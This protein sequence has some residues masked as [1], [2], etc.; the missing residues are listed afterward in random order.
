MAGKH[1][2]FLALCV[3][4]LLVSPLTALAAGTPV[5][6]AVGSSGALSA[7]TVG[8][9]DEIAEP[10]T[11]KPQLHERT[12]LWWPY[13]EGPIY[14]APSGSL[15]GMDVIRLAVG[16]IRAGESLDLPAD[17]V[18]DTG[19]IARGMAQ[20]FLVQF[21]ADDPGAA[22]QAIESMGAVVVETIPVNAAIVRLDGSNYDRVASSPAV[23]FIE[24]Y[25]PAFRIHPAVGQM[26]QL[27]PEAAA[28]P[29][30]ELSVNLFPGEA[31]APVAQ[32]IEQLGGVVRA[33][34]DG[35]HPELWIS[36]NA[37]LIPQLARLEPV[38]MI[39]ERG[40]VLPMAARGSLFLQS[41]S[42]LA[43]DYPYWEAGVDGDGQIIEVDDSGLSVDAGDFSDTAAD[44]GWTGTGGNAGPNVGPGHR[45]V[46]AYRTASSLS[47]GG[48]GDLGACDSAASG[49]F[50]HGQVVGGVAAGNATRDQVPA[51]SQP[52]PGAG[53]GPGFYDD[54]NA[55]G[56]FDEIN[57]SAFD[58]IAKGAK[59]VFVDAASGCPDAADP[60][61]QPGNLNTIITQTSQQY[62]AHIHNFSFGSTAP[63]T[64]PSYSAGADDID[65]AIN[66]APINFVAISAGND[67]DPDA[68]KYDI[69][70]QGNEASCKNC[71]AVGA[72]NGVGG[73][74]WSFTSGGT[75]PGR[76][77]LTLLF[78]EGADNSCRSEDA[79]E[80]PAENQTGPAT[81]RDAG[82]Q[83]GTSF[84]SPNLAGAAAVIRDYFAKGFYP[85][86]TDRNSNNPAEQVDK[87]SGA[88]IKAIMIA[89]AQPL[90]TGRTVMPEDRFNFYW[91]Y[92]RVQLNFSL[93]LSDFPGKTVSGLIV[94][95]SADGT[96]IDNDGS[97]DSTIASLSL[98]TGLL[99]ATPTTYTD[100][101]EVLDDTEDLVVAL[102]WNDVV[103]QQGTIAND[104]DLRLRYCG[105]DGTCGNGD[106]TVWAGNVF[107][108]DYDRDGTID[109]DLN[110]NGQPDEYFYSLE[111]R[112]P[113]DTWVD[114]VNNTEAVFVPTE[115]NAQDKDGDGTFDMALV[116]TGT[117]R[118]EIERVSGS[119]GVLYALA[120]TGGVAAG[121]SARF[122]TNPLVC[123]ADVGVLVNE[124]DDPADTD[125]NAGSC[126][127]SVISARTTVEV[128]DTADAVVDT[129]TG[130]AFANT[131]GLR[132]ESNR[133]PLSADLAPAA[134][135]GVLSVDNGYKLR[136][137]YQDTDTDRK[138]IATVDCQPNIEVQL[139]RQI[140]KD[141]P[142][143]LVGGCDDDEY[144]D[145]GEA[146]SIELEYFNLDPF[147]LIDAQI[148]LRAV[149]PYPD[150]TDPQTIADDPCRLNRP[151][152][153]YI[154]I[155][156]PVNDVAVL[157][158][159]TRQRTN[160]TFQVAGTP[161][162]RE[163]V[164]LV[165]GLTGAKTGQP[166]QDCVA[167]SFLL[168][169]DDEQNRYITDCPTGCTADYDL[170][171]DE[172]WDD[173][174]PRNPFDPI[175]F[176]NRGED[177][178]AIVYGDLTDTSF[179]GPECPNCGNDAL[180]FTG[181]WNFD[182]D[183][184]GF[185][186]GVSPLSALS[187][188]TTQ[189]TNWGED[190]NWD[191]TLQPAE[192]I[193]PDGA[194]G[195]LDQNWGLGGGC[196]FVSS[197]GTNRGIWHT[198]TIGTWQTNHTTISCRPDDTICEEYDVQFGTTG[199][200]YWFQTLRTP[201]IHPVRLGT[202]ADGFEWTAQIR[203]WSW[204]WQ[205]DTADT[206]QSWTWEFDLD[207]NTANPLQLGDDFIGGL[208]FGNQLGVISGGQT[209]IF[210]GAFAFNPTIDDST[211]IN[212]GDERLGSKGNDRDS[213]RGCYF[214]DLDLEP[215][216]G[217][218]LT[219]AERQVNPVRPI[220]DDCD[221]NFDLV[222]GC[223]G[224]C[225]V[226]D[227]GNGAIDDPFEICPCR[228]CEAGSPRAGQA[229]LTAAQCNPEPG[230]SFR[231]VDN[232]N[233][234]GV[235]SGFG[236][237]I[238]GNGQTDEN[239]LAD[240]GTAAGLRQI[241]NADI[242]MLNGVAS[243]GRGAGD[244]RFNTLDDFY[245]PTG[246]S[247]AGELGFLVAEPEGNDAAL[248]SYGIGVDDMVVEWIE[249]HPIDDTAAVCTAGNPDY[250][251]QCARI[252]LG[253][254]FN[255]ND[256]DGEIPVTV[257]DFNA[258]TTENAVDC[259]GDGQPNEIQIQAFSEAE[260]IPELFCLEPTSPGSSQY[261]GTI[262]TTT[263]IRTL[264]D[265]LVYLAWN[266]N[267]TPSITARYI[268]KNDGVHGFNGGPD[269]QPGIAGFDD[270]GDGTIDN[271]E[272]LCPEKTNLGPGRSPHQPGTPAR[273]SDDECGCPDNI[274][275]S[276]FA[277]FDPA[278]VLFV[279]YEIDDSTGDND[280]WP[281]PGE[282][283]TLNI[284]VRNLSDF[285]LENVELIIASDS[286][287]VDCVTDDR[288]IIPR[289]EKRGDPGDQV[290]TID[291]GDSFSFVAA[292]G[293]TRQTISERF[294]SEWTISMRA[295]GKANPN[296]SFDQDIPIS[297]TLAVQQF[298]V[299]HNLD[300]AGTPGAAPDFVDDFES[301]AGDNDLRANWVPYVTG[302]DPE[303]LDGTHCQTNDPFNPFGN[304]TDPNDFCELG[305]G[306]DN[307]EEHW[308][309]NAA[310]PSGADTVC[311]SPFGC[312]DAGRSMPGGTA[313]LS[314]SNT[315][316][317]D[318]S[319]I[320]DGF[321]ID[322]NRMNWVQ[323]KTNFQLGLGEPELEYWTQMSI[324]DNR[325]FGQISPPF[326]FDAGLVYV[327]I[328]ENDN[329]ECDTGQVGAHVDNG[330]RWEPIRAYFSPEQNF[331][332]N[333]FINCMYDPSDDGTT[334][335]MFFPNALDQGPSSTCFPGNPV[336]TC[337]GRTRD[338]GTGFG[339]VGNTFGSYCWPET[340]AEDTEIGEAGA[341]NAAG[342][343]YG[344]GTWVRKAFKLERFRGQKI[345]VRF[346]VSPGG[347]PGIENTAA[348]LG[349]FAG[350]RDDG[351]FIDN[352]R[353]TGLST[354]FSLAVDNSG[355][356]PG[357]CGTVAECTTVDASLAVLSFPRNDRNGNPKPALYCSDQN[358][359]EC[360]FDG[361]GV[362]DSTAAD[363]T[364]DAPG[365]PF[366]LEARF[367]NADKCLGGALEF[368]F[369]DLTNGLVV[370]DWLTDPATLVNP[371][372]TTTYRLEVRCSSSPTCADQVD[373]TIN[374]NFGPTV[375]RTADLTFA[376]DK[377][378]VTWAADPNAACPA[379]F[380]TLRGDVPSFGAGTCLE[381]NGTDTTSTDA[382]QPAAGAAFWYLTRHDADTYSSGGPGEQDRSGITGCP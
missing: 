318:G 310:A 162:G 271:A 240:F 64:G 303:E 339:A 145:Q 281:D 355:T 298:F 215:G 280:G 320:D 45:K 363:V 174:I 29:V 283:V 270:D 235:P 125:C 133:L 246:D 99:P 213:H 50:T 55:D 173:A 203:D 252:A 369:T 176:L 24:P 375:C 158:T 183:D 373:V 219:A 244:P 241:R 222:D 137:T 223:P 86:G 150:G 154:D 27:T 101:F 148:S 293:V 175:D 349:P 358:T 264:G 57:D 87:I 122:D 304:N 153:P 157:P 202:D 314:N 12:V 51:P 132:F 289:L 287:T 128:L 91:G 243:G 268:D 85:D 112:G 76:R 312:P 305:E 220:D 344:P 332:Q 34:F 218:G 193:D 59:I 180:S 20:Y 221:N 107:S 68:G 97:I 182:S 253:V 30:F 75:G 192:D 56:S 163:Q 66:N 53:Y 13:N 195:T 245:G 263:R 17:L 337:V 368:R 328:D 326:A 43:G 81:C 83:L 333:N 114:S 166:V 141:F 214:N 70:V 370:R 188:D 169:A 250:D 103:N 31:V 279:D 353:I 121:S 25:H 16:D 167:Y 194:V 111:R 227:D 206:N 286:A 2:F 354:D 187:P 330:E 48:G 254:A 6:S 136:V 374:S 7:G 151:D 300:T 67:G 14:G 334:E 164:E 376:A 42:G 231:C 90:T 316:D 382:T 127:A 44:S 11:P 229:C 104:L 118:V 134:G 294:G 168:S 257:V 5:G 33:A 71:V 357:T 313:S 248:Q 74:T 201:T 288:V 58:G 266:G 160:F 105:A 365:R 336:D 72:S 96:D 184:E 251:G 98:P 359:D 21:S 8:Q 274:V 239:V 135:D 46:V 147:D 276:T 230:T 342:G 278:D 77:V 108:E 356:N 54:N 78:A 209:N 331:R 347:L 338:E 247:W 89:G 309:L 94:H 28:S 352:V 35:T 256:G 269:G 4:A 255:T 205:V 345:L 93:P 378:T 343:A 319:L 143:N 377:Q 36:L 367:S 32:A 265:G 277:A 341:I 346:H 225:G 95:D 61:L 189:V 63:P 41:P 204:N 159:Q 185:T 19:A 116:Q 172:R 9:A 360:D 199:Q 181:P 40:P 100:E 139:I 306:Y 380:D 37:S 321:T 366:V 259:N 208:I 290:R 297:G 65:T 126:P 237:D 262:K 234:A 113:N 275:D 26:K 165:F 282:E 179:R 115:N 161:P 284:T 47:P 60:S 364:A 80:T 340:G 170:N 261:R 69:G 361:D 109:N 38:A 198:G 212:Y 119:D 110:G 372:S 324:T 258:A 233:A 371:T 335:D 106:D 315:R 362:V 149:T 138:S 217:P 197:N 273:Y 322:H 211:S 291:V 49:S 348:I 131:A 232:T 15:D 200:E 10:T 62:G 351:W 52:S 299:P 296:T 285:A 308:H 84:A 260:R 92:G 236:D 191:N 18:A 249:S 196:G 39:T 177:E 190:T 329:N 88:L 228:V 216:D 117:W 156:N 379:L 317:A 327:C 129:E 238:C 295:L 130:L 323:Y 242:S 1:W 22:R 272:E 301:Y 178:T 102:V 350:N 23:R 123:N 267:D 120:I 144:L 124:T 210:G 381:D 224:L 155:E 171:Q 226:D 3:S 146:F 292:T 307:T 140:G 311:F 325:L 82:T 186:T 152:S 73:G 142:F 79:G 302:D 207:T